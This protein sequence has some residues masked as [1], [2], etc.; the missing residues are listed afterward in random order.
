VQAVY[1]RPHPVLAPFVHFS[2]YFRLDA[3]PTL[4]RVLPTGELQLLVNLRQD[5]LRTYGHDGG[6][7]VAP[8]GGAA[9]QGAQMCHSVIDTSQQNAVVLVCFKPGGAYPFFAP[10]PGATAE[11]LV[12][13]GQLWGRTGGVLRERLLATS[14]PGD[15]LRL[16]EATVLESVVRPLE[17]DPMVRYAVAALDR[18]DSVG[19][20][21]ERLGMSPKRVGR[22]FTEQ[23][24]LTPKRFS[25]VRRFQRALR[26]IPHDRPVDW[27]GI[28]A[29]CGY[30]DQSHFIHDFRAFS[31]ISPTG[32]RP[33]SPGEPNHVPIG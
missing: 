25:R 18:G 9:L 29:T 3:P 22:R 15:M 16:L 31:G 27:A 20:V 7:T 10:P 8:I 12:E 6:E 11:Q 4:E 23:V 1:R 24:G 28:A 21:T 17:P 30:F 33:R 13:V 32:Y 19:E 14:N 26:S 5:E 2:G